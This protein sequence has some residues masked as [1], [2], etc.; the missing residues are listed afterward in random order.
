[1][2]WLLARLRRRRFVVDRHWTGPLDLFGHPPAECS[3]EGCGA[4]PGDW[5]E[6]APERPAIARR[7]V[8]GVVVHRDAV[9]IPS[10]HGK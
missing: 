9:V 5:V 10:R 4:R 7:T 2:R 8:P 6:A 3:L 1:M